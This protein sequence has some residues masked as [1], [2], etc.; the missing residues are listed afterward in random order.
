MDEASIVDPGGSLR[1]HEEG[2]HGYLVRHAT[3]DL[4]RMSRTDSKPA[5]CTLGDASSHDQAE[6]V[7]RDP[8][9]LK[10]RTVCVP[11][12]LMK[13]TLLHCRKC[14][15]IVRHSQEGRFKAE[16]SFDH[17]LSGVDGSLRK[18]L[19]TLGGTTLSNIVRLVME[20]TVRKEIQLQFSLMGRK[21][22]RSF[23]GTRLYDVVLESCGQAP[24]WNPFAQLLAQPF[25][26]SSTEPAAE[27]A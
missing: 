5:A 24:A 23:K 16:G 3:P 8:K 19:S 15:R 25:A 18:E 9:R 1:T 20:R 21:G 26:L 10:N 17:L 22:K 4:T 6:L 27:S 11:G 7:L 12:E 14:R 2:L 13:K